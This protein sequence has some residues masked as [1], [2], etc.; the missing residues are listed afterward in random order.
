MKS[1]L[2]AVLLAC[3]LGLVTA[4][5]AETAAKPPAAQTAKAAPT[6]LKTL[7]FFKNPN[8]RPCQNQQ[9]ILDGIQE[10]LKGLAQVKIV[11][12]LVPEDLAQFEQWGI[13]GLPMLIIA[14]K[15][16]REL[17]RF[18]PGVQDGEAI[19]AQLRK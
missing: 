3:A 6:G 4:C 12:T 8:G 15:D 5:S 14:D 13:R 16:G 11:S 2:S 9:A 10:P 1:S 17:H 19:L 18:F 7:F